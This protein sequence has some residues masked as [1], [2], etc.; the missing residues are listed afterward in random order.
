MNSPHWKQI[1]D[2]FCHSKGYSR[3]EPRAAL[4]D[5]DG[6]LYDSMPGHARAWMDMCRGEGIEATPD[7]FFMA[8]GRTG[9]DT[10]EMLMQRSFGRSAT[11]AD[12]ERLYAI[13]SANFRAQPLVGVMPGAQ[14]AVAHCLQRGL[15]TVL[16]T[17]SGQTSLID[18]LAADYPGAFAMKVSSRDVRHG[19]PRPEPY[20]RA[21]QLAQVQ[22]WQAIVVEN[23]PL[24]VRSGAAAGVFTV[25]VV[26]GPMPAH[27]LA[28]AGAT[29]VFGSMPEFSEALP[30]MLRAMLDS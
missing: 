29:V 9:A 15:A 1:I 23:A 10:I 4:F 25:G 11:A 22:P 3:L 24:G 6:T 28:D 21:M 17:G 18:R 27:V 13:K 2:S 30:E 7:D 26:T 8:E 20:L 19:K 16:V 5:M 12:V 14:S